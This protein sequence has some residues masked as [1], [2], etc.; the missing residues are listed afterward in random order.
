MKKLLFLSLLLLL[1]LTVQT[2]MAKKNHTKVDEKEGVSE[3]RLQNGLKV[4]I[5]EDH[6]APVATFMVLYRVGSRNEATGYTGLTHFLE[7]MLFKDTKNFNKKKNNRIIKILDSIGADFNGTTWLDRTNYFATVPIQH[8]ELYMQ[9]EADRMQN[10]ILDP[11]EVKNERVVVLNELERADNRPDRLMNRE[12]YAQAFREH[13]YHH[14]TLGWRSDVE[15]FSIKM[16]KYFYETYY[17]PNNATVIIV[18]DVKPEEA[19]AKVEKHFGKIKPAQK[20]IPTVYTAEPPQKGERRFLLNHP[21]PQ[22]VVM[23][24][25]HTPPATHEDTPAILVMDAIF[26]GAWGKKVSSRLYQAFVEKKLATMAVSNPDETRDP[27]LFKIWAELHKGVELIKAERIFWKEIEKIQQGDFSK[28]EIKRAKKQIEVQ[29]IYG[30][31]GMNHLAFVLGEA[32]AAG[33]WKLFADK[34]EKVKKVTKEDIIR[35][36]NK[37]LVR[38]NAT[39]GWL[40][41]TDEGAGSKEATANKLFDPKPLDYFREEGRGEAAKKVGAAPATAVIPKTDY[42]SRIKTHTLKNGARLIML[43]APESKTFT[44]KGALE[45]GSNLNGKGRL[46][47][48]S[49]TADLLDKGTEKHTKLELAEIMESNGIIINFSTDWQNLNFTLDTIAGERKR[50][51]ELLREML[52]EPKF[53]KEELEKRKQMLKT[54]IDVSEMEPTSAAY[55]EMTRLIYPEGHA[56]YVY[57]ADYRKK[58]VEKLSIEEIETFYKSNYGGEGMIVSVV[59]NFKTEEFIAEMEAL[60]GD[61]KGAPYRRIEVSSPEKYSPQRKIFEIPGKESDTIMFSI[62]IALSRKSEDYYAAKLAN[63]IIGGSSLISR[64]GE[65]IRGKKGLTYGIYSY[66]D[67]H[68]YGEGLWNVKATANPKL[69]GNLIAAVKEVLSVARK[70]GAAKKELDETKT[71][72][73]GRFQVGLISNAAL[74]D[75]LFFI[76]EHNMGLDY[77]DTYLQRINEIKLKEVNEAIVKYFNVEGAAMVIAGPKPHLVLD[78]KKSVEE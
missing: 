33:D 70:K 9:M 30:R 40:N 18:G 75:N 57:P 74:C 63:E 7:H 47:I 62:P 36:A 44:L 41:P 35:V 45:A 46:F 67:N 1:T 22:P 2:A 58:Q 23:L 13:P 25:F 43:E 17:R 5:A 19:L 71:G 53:D 76:L 65:D 61:W 6:R 28:K 8:L 27:G 55:F 4:L 20:P 11:D 73:I 38:D 34:L 56:Y 42:Q 50:A 54:Q 37:Y 64:L 21:A 68:F 31:E 14:P 59:G 49:S 12:L 60:F 16:V 24:G 15:N 52:R 77:L 10:L 3:Y 48:A 26:S 39:I 51:L 72:E 66:F 32:E 78:G 69:A 29:L